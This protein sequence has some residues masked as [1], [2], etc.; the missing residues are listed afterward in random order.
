[1]LVTLQTSLPPC[2]ILSSTI[3][4][5]LQPSLLPTFPSSTS[6]SLF[7]NTRSTRAPFLVGSSTTCIRK[8]LS[9]LCRNLLDCSRS[10]K[11]KK[12]DVIQS[13]R[14][15]LNAGEHRGQK[16]AEGLLPTQRCLEGP[17]FNTATSTNS[18]SPVLMSPCFPVGWLSMLF[19]CL[20]KNSMGPNSCYLVK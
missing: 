12:P 16:D 7:V 13:L 11:Q 10:K 1:M 18:P 5:S 4:W 20:N 9:M 14:I 17:P 8:L 3:S 6:P 19:L 2:R 15:I